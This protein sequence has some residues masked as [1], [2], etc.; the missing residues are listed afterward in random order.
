MADPNPLAGMPF[1]ESLANNMNESLQWMSRMWG[2]AAAA[3]RTGAESMFSPQ[4]PLAPGVPSMLMPTLDPQELDKRICDLKTVAHWLDMNRALLHTTIQTLEM[5]RNGI[6]ALQSMAR[7]AQAVAS[8]AAQPA[9][10]APAEAAAKPGAGGAAAQPLPFDPTQW[11][12]ALQDQFARVAAA[13]ATAPP[14]AD[15]P[16]APAS[17]AP[18]APGRSAADVPQAPSG[19]KAGRKP[20]GSA[21]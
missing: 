15:A 12:T 19:N 14:E 7:S 18:P 9:A 16:A 2:N 6:V 20:S 3:P 11:W 1:A 5:Q 8:G 21:G 10:A 17:G 4:S 13:A